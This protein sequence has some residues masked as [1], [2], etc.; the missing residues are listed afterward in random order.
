MKLTSWEVIIVD[1]GFDD[2]R[3]LE[4]IF[5]HHGAVVHI[6]RNG[7]ECSELLE[8]VMPVVIVTDLAMPER[9]GWQTLIAVRSDVRTAHIPVIAVTAYHTD[10]LDRKALMAG[11]DAYFP[12]PLHPEQFVQA[13]TQI[14]R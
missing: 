12:K 1:D 6:A 11:F 9:D 8:R 4:R 14:V 13:L 10:G 5:T 3:V 7:T 2:Q